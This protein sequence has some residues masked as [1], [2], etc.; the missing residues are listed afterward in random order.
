M[1]YLILCTLCKYQDLRNTVLRQTLIG[2]K[3][4][5]KH[6]NL[7]IVLSTGRARAPVYSS[8]TSATSATSGQSDKRDG[9]RG[10]QQQ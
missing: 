1:K 8:A 3:K 6:L 10:D 9:A 7:F 4:K 2:A 5:K